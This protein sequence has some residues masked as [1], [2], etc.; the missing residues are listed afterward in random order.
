MKKKIYVIMLA[1]LLSA[2]V[3][4]V[5]TE[6]KFDN[7]LDRKGTNLFE[8]QLKDN[9]DYAGDTAGA[10]GVNGDGV[11]N[12]FTDPKYR[13]KCDASMPKL[14]LVGPSTVTINTQQIDEFRK[15]MH[16]TGGGW[17]S[18]IKWDGGYTDIDPKA[19]RLTRGGGQEVTVESG[20]TPEPGTNYM[21]IYRI[22]RPRCAEDKPVPNREESRGLIVEEYKAPDTATPRMVL[23]GAATIDVKQGEKYVDDGVVVMLGNTV[24]TESLLDSV[25][26]KM[27]SKNEQKLT[28]PVDFSKINI[29][30]AVDAG[31]RYTITYYA[32]RNGKPAEP[33]FLI[34][35]VNIAEQQSG[36]SKAVIVLEPYKHNI[37]GKTIY[38]KDTVMSGGDTYVEKGVKRVYY[39]KDGAEEPVDAG[40]V[41]KT[42][43][44][45]PTTVEN[46][47]QRSLSYTLKAGAGYAAADAVSRYVYLVVRGC[48]TPAPPTITFVEEG[49]ITITAGVEW[50]YDNGWSVKNQD[51]D[52][53]QDWSTSGGK[54]YIVDLDGMDPKKPAKGTYNVTYV[55]L[56]ACGSIAKR[57]RTVTVK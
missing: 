55:G 7:P 29:N 22:E 42:A 13:K 15:W 54:K 24:S 1:A 34:R 44:T 6:V 51:R 37:D 16:L 49:N 36:G 9:P 30:T 12:Y 20:K 53:D 25:V 23:E 4:L 57:E 5:C 8:N 40:L 31:S 50:N 19:P 10:F 21:I 27:G 56:G 11:A 39:M 43:I 48:D 26:V 28:K 47:G 46:P 17:D 33:K 18:L 41:E 35:T 2:A 3:V 32:S 45:I 38:H 52:G 14:T